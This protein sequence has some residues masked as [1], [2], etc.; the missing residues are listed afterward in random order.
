MLII[1]SILE[2]IFFG[3]LCFFLYKAEQWRKI[4]KILKNKAKIMEEELKIYREAEKIKMKNIV[5]LL[6]INENENE[7]GK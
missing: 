5:S 3:V 2:I 4:A 7:K 1:F 6:S